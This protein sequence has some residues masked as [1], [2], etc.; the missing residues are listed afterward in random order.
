MESRVR[1]YIGSLPNSVLDEYSFGKLPRLEG[2]SDEVFRARL[3]DFHESLG[4]E[5]IGEGRN[6]GL[7]LPAEHR[8]PF[9][10]KE[11]KKHRFVRFWLVCVFGGLQAVVVFCGS[12]CYL[13]YRGAAHYPIL[14]FA[15][16][17]AG[18]LAAVAYANYRYIQQMDTVAARERQ[19]VV[20][21]VG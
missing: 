11:W 20:G 4:S 18:I 1:R 16:P 6:E 3:A 7:L 19:R 21:D 15:W 10:H 2:E 17:L 13:H 8:P 9:D 5:I 12:I 14:F